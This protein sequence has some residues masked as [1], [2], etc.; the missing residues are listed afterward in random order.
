MTIFVLAG[1][2]LGGLVGA[3]IGACLATILITQ[4][5]DVAR[6]LRKST[7]TSGRALQGCIPV[8]RAFLGTMF[9]QRLMRALGISFLVAMLTAMGHAVGG[10]L[11]AMIAASLAVALGQAL[12]HTDSQSEYDDQASHEATKWPTR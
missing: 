2:A 9:A 10:K 5:E 11:G 1:H 3:V 12:S 6:I 4:T 7:D 8:L